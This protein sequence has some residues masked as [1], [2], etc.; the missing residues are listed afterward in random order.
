MRHAPD[1]ATC[2]RMQGTCEVFRMLKKTAGR[3]E[4]DH[5]DGDELKVTWGEG[6]ERR[7]G[8]L[9]RGRSESRER[10]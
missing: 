3:V 1:H 5:P 7:D 6:D 4:K 8:A 2:G 9:V 10:F